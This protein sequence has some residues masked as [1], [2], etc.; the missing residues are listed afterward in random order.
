MIEKRIRLHKK[1][2]A[3]VYAILES[4]E[5]MTMYSTLPDEPGTIHRDLKLVIPE[6]FVSDIEKILDGMRN[7]FPILEMKAEEKV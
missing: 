2:T 1:D 4:L 3:F 5:G 6:G 7:K